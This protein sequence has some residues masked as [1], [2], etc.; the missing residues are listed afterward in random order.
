MKTKRGFSFIVII[1]GIIVTF[2]M[3]F[4]F[5]S[6]IIGDIIKGGIGALKEIPHALVQWHDNPTGFFF[7]YLL[8]YGFVWW[9]R[10]A[11]AL[12]IM[13]GSLLWTIINIDNTGNLI[14]TLPTFAVGFFYLISWLLKERRL[15]VQP[16]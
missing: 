7:T 3:V 1:Y 11:G 16:D 14:F 8:G 5:G 9:K 10:L 2:L 4:I 13:A 15:N 6:Y 12:I